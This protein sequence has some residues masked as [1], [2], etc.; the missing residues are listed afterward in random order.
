MRNRG[1]GAPHQL[2]RLEGSGSL[3]WQPGESDACAKAAL[4]HHAFS[5]AI[6]VYPTV[7]AGLVVDTATMVAAYVEEPQPLLESSSPAGGKRAPRPLLCR[8]TLH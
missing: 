2:L 5:H 3:R 8:D 4:L 7:S 1:C 6:N